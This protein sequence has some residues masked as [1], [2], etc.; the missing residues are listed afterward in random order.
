MVLA[1]LPQCIMQTTVLLSWLLLAGPACTVYTPGTPGAAWSQDELLAVKAKLRKVLQLGGGPA[2]RAA[3]KAL[4]LPASASQHLHWGN[5]P[6][7]AKM[8]RLS[9]HD[10]L[11]YTD[12]SGGCDGCLEW[13]GMGRIFQAW[14]NRSYEDSQAGG[15]NNGLQPTVELLEA[16]YTVPDFPANSPILHA[17]LAQAGKSRADLWALAALVAVEW[18][19]ETNNLVCED[20]A[21]YKVNSHS[22]NG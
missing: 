11:L 15:G 10:C 16:I 1:C 8:L 20:P 12:G 5:L 17:S 9:F 3:H 21:A 14:T 18:G 13:T 22:S 6:N 4:G 2:I 19:V 7:A